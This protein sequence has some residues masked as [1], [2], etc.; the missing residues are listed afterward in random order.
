MH[1]GHQAA[2]DA[3]G[4][5]DDLGQRRQ[6]VGCTRSIGDNRLARIGGAVDAKDEHWRVIL[7]WRRHDDFLSACVDVFLRRFFR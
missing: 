2:L 3:E 5:V 7:R 6:A 1:R 4:V